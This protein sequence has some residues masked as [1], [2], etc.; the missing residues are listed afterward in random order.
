MRRVA[1]TSDGIDD[2]REWDDSGHP[3]AIDEPG[4]VDAPFRPS[5]RVRRQ[6][7][8]YVGG[9]HDVG[10]YLFGKR[11]AIGKPKIDRE[12]LLN[13]RQAAHPLCQRT[14][15]CRVRDARVTMGGQ[16]PQTGGDT[17]LTIAVVSFI[18]V[19]VVEDMADRV[20]AGRRWPQDGNQYSL[21]DKIGDQCLGG[22]VRELGKGGGKRFDQLRPQQRR[23]GR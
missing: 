12:R 18:R 11:D 1:Q 6:P 3:V 9:H 10:G 5:R 14:R 13:V 4:T 8:Q 21:V 22:L 2:I 16:R 19:K 7:S 23:G 20:R 17:P 15:L